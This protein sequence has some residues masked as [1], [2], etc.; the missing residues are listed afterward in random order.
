MEN[1]FEYDNAVSKMRKFFRELNGFVEVPTQSRRSILAACEDPK[2]VSQYIFSGINWPL[3]QTGQMWLEKEMLDNPDLPG[4]F[5][6]STSY[7]NEPN[8]I[9]GR[10]DKIFPMFE[11]ESK[12][13]VEDMI[14][15]ETELL[16]H[17]GFDVTRKIRATY[18]QMCRAYNTKLL[19]ADHETMMW[20]DVSDVIFLTDFPLRSDP[21]WNMKQNGNNFNKVDVIL[22]GMETVGSAERSC[23]VTEMRDN[24]YSV[25]DGEY[26]SLLFNHFGRKRVEDEL[27]EYFE[28]NMI[29]R[30]GG[31][32]GVTRMAR[33]LRLHEQKNRATE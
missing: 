9:P 1:I 6:I 19:E 25:S 31:G 26:A 24:F 5:C 14:N 28:L 16:E 23:N 18:N 33:A 2:T 32:I 27:E 7:R 15:L 13:S 21:F 17:M 4:V 10:H 20:N 22:Y 29:P 12:G 11:F 30:F 8:P 3:P